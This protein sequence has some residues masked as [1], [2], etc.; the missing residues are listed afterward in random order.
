MESIDYYTLYKKY[1]YKYKTAF[2]EGGGFGVESPGDIDDESEPKFDTTKHKKKFFKNTLDDKKQSL[3]H[4]QKILKRDLDNLKIMNQVFSDYNNLVKNPKLKLTSQM[5][6]IFNVGNNP[7]FNYKDTIP[8]KLDPS[9]W[10]NL[11]QSFKK[12]GAHHQYQ[13]I[14]HQ[15]NP[16]SLYEHLSKICIFSYAN[17]YE[18]Y[19]N[20]LDPKSDRSCV[21]RSN[22]P[23][24]FSKILLCTMQQEGLR[25][26][27]HKHPCKSNNDNAHCHYSDSLD[28]CLPKYIE[29][30]QNPDKKRILKQENIPQL[31]YNSVQSLKKF[32][33]V[34]YLIGQFRHMTQNKSNTILIY[35]TSLLQI[36]Q[37]KL[38][39][40]KYMYRIIKDKHNK[41]KE[42]NDSDGDSDGDPSEEQDQL[43]RKMFIYEEI[44][45]LIDKYIKG[46]VKLLQTLEKIDENYL[47]EYTKKLKD[48][49]PQH[50]NKKY[51]PPLI[52]IDKHIF[53]VPKT[54][55]HDTYYSKVIKDE[56]QIPPEIV[57]I[58]RP[59]VVN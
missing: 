28:I 8:L 15:L 41:S 18:S 47:E 25:H 10:N 9:Q 7:G 55:E 58:W 50:P 26:K 6:D 34:D 43:K 40:I 49:T 20:H 52:K 38:K 32:A 42:H 17:S 39:N 44:I 14:T 53:S 12:I 56:V 11:E 16:T 35:W 37:E 23:D 45:K 2:Y 51:F 31:L 5:R 54:L 22:K 29:P 4:K 24:I 3:E 36:S 27:D 21:T 48:W 30:Q 33:E 57:N 19:F 13:K 1:K 46:I 59:M